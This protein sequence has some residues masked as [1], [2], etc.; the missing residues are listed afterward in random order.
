MVG[1]AAPVAAWPAPRSPS[2]AGK[3]TAPFR[4][5]VGAY[6]PGWQMRGSG[7]ATAA[8]GS[9]HFGAYAPT[10]IWVEGIDSSV[11]HDRDG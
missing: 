9:L 6:E 10:R 7:A 4:M 5:R 3:F 8:G 2:S 1:I 11:E